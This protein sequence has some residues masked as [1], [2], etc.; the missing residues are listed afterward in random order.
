MVYLT[1]ISKKRNE[2]IQER[3]IETNKNP[4]KENCPQNSWQITTSYNDK[5]ESSNNYIAPN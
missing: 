3:R 2:N 5:S 4:Q 1:E